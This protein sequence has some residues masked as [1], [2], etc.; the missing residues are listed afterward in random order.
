VP[1]NPSNPP[2]REGFLEALDRLLARVTGQFVSAWCI[3]HLDGDV[4]EGWTTVAYLSALHPELLWGHTVLSNGFRNPALVVKMSATLSFMSGGR[5][6]LGIGAGGDE[7]EHLAYG[8]DFPEGGARVDALDEALTIIRAMWTQERVT[9][10]GTHYRV[11]DA[12]CEP[13]PAPPPPIAVGAFGPRMLRLTARHAD[14]WNVSSTSIARYRELVDGLERACAETGRDPATLRRVWS[15]GCAC[16]PTEAEVAKLAGDRLQ[17]GEDL[18]GTPAQVIE[19]MQPFVELG[20][21]CFL[22]DCGGFPLLT[23]V[24]TLVD[25]VIPVLNR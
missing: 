20:V 23:T 16:A 5:Y 25:E 2:S 13:G 19:Q 17:V 9:F 3:D 24:E 4:L 21:D 15:G 11:I 8:Y 12:R 14:W 7:R 1:D 18:V 6:V 22:L 10:E